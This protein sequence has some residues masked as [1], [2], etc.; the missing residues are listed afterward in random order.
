MESSRP[1]AAVASYLISLYSIIEESPPATAAK[2]I[3]HLRISVGRE[4]LG[5]TASSVNGM[6]KRL[7]RD[8]VIEIS[9]NELSLTQTGQGMAAE[10]FRRHQL[11]ERFLHDVLG[12]E[13]HRV[14]A[15]AMSWHVI[16]PGVEA[17][18]DE[19]LNHPKTC[20]FG[21]PIPGSG[22]AGNPRA[23]PLQEFRPGGRGVIERIPEEEPNL[24]EYFVETGIRPGNEVEFKEYAAFKGTTTLIVNNQEVI[25]SPAVAAAIWAE[26]QS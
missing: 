4:A 2:L 16:S 10:T 8:G 15:E 26:P 11:A 23:I 22:Y 3:R 24:L 18:M 21:H 6:L 17:K 25:V 14:H 9:R 7:K 1:S 12:V 13:L 5:T 20:P 19:V